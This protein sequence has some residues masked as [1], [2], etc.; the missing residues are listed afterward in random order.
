VVTSL[1]ADELGAAA[2]DGGAIA[3]G[4][5]WLAGA[6]GDDGAE[7]PADVSEDASS[8]PAETVVEETHVQIGHSVL[9][10]GS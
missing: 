6:D 10:A 9:V 4:T 8:G 2:T 7:R 1:R 3:I 5:A